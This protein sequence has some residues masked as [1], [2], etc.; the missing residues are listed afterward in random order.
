M[1]VITTFVFVLIAVFNVSCKPEK[2]LV[3]KKI[4]LTSDRVSIVEYQNLKLDASIYI[5]GE[6]SET[7][8]VGDVLV[9]IIDNGKVLVSFYIDNNDAG[10][11][12][13]RR[14][15]KNYFMTL[16]V[17]KGE[18]SIAVEESV[19]GKPFA[20]QSGLGVACV[21]DI[22]LEITNF[23]HEWTVTESGEHDS[24]DV[25]Y[26]LTTRVGDVVENHCFYS[27]DIGNGYIIELGD[28]SIEVLS[29][30]YNNNDCIVE[31]VINRS[32]LSPM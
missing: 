6:N 25:N 32:Y 9:N 4:A 21:G 26:T 7:H 10:Q 17:D 20:L 18:Y 28:Y 5:Y 13:H 19:F 3:M 31:V 30:R 12:Y 24:D 11:I 15:Y 1:K 14:I 2:Q 23:M 16:E 22:E 8:L 27:S 29:D